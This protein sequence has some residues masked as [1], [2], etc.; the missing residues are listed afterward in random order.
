MDKIRGVNLGNWLV[1]EKWMDINLFR[2]VDAEDEVWMARTMPPEALAARLKEH[3]ETFVTAEDFAAIKAHGANLVRL[4]VPYFVFG[5]RPP[6]V[7]CIEYVDR[8]MDW[9]EQYDLPVMLDLHTVPGSQ[10]GYDNGGITGVCKWCKQ[11]G[12][13]QFA[14]SVLKR[15]AE[16]YGHR[17]GLWGIQ[18]I[19]EPISWLVYT[20]AP[21]T[22]RARDKEEAKGSGCV[23]LRFLRSFYLD[24]YRVLREH[25]AED[26]VVVFHDGFRL[27]RWKKFF[28]R[29]GL[30]NVLLDT[31]IYIFAMEGFVPI[32]QLWV[33]KL[34][35]RWNERSIRRVSRYVPV[36]VGEWCNSHKYAVSRADN[37]EE[38]KRRFREVADMQLKAWSVSAG[39][40]YWSY[41][42]WRDRE[43]P[44]DDP[45]K[46]PWD[47]ARCWSR[48]W[49]PEQLP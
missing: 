39:Y 1:L 2:D 27:N 29:S 10:N 37:P 20:T 45:W 17:R 49:M 44:M 38:Q 43:S 16:R 13:V 41:Q 28:T 36:V 11:P 32:H 40:I 34:F 14:L 26:K 35:V 30:K 15:L 46:E 4:P 3:R 19:N 48:G 42:L 8:A 18:V 23:P 47:L 24:A 12:E 7:G 33:Y 6:F 9:A 22:G 31:H 5:D 21:S 25:M